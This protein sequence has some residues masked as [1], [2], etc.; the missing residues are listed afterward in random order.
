MADN[1]VLHI[2]AG[3]GY[4]DDSHVQDY[5]GLPRD[6]PAT[7]LYFASQPHAYNQDQYSISFRFTP[8]KPAGDE[9]PGISGTDLQFGND[10]DHPIRD[11]LP[12]GFNTAMS[13]V[14]CSF[15][16]IHV[17]SGEYDKAKGGLWFEEG[18]DEAGLKTR[19][20]LAVPEAN[21][22][23]MKWALRAENK[24]KWVW[25]YDRTY[26]LDFFN[27]HLDFANLALKLPGFQLPIMKYW[28][29]WGLRY[30]LRN[31]DTDQTYLVIIF[32]LYYKDYVNEDGSLKPGA[33]ES[34]A[35]R[36]DI[37]IPDEEIDIDEAEALKEAG[38]KFGPKFGEEGF[39]KTSPDDVD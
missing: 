26:G 39:E 7:S 29:G 22:A 35:E 33:K 21:K 2:T 28:D 31:K 24:E 1:Y 30:V 17:G 34:I 13:I 25:Q 3:P 23:R 10:F 4:D 19:Q 38:E 14:K 6:A 16:T 32:T 5:K 12:P 27:P 36:R 18:G 9:G 37:P 20:E 11:R 15:N 8:K